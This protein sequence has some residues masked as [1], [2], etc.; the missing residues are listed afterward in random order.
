MP[1][2]AC[3]LPAIEMP[4]SIKS[5]GHSKGRNHTFRP[6]NGR[7]LAGFASD[8]VDMATLAMV[9]SHSTETTAAIKWNAAT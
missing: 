8:G 2:T 7:N 1:S 6:L 9:W 5:S 4:H 3:P